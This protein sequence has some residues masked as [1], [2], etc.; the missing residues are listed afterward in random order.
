MTSPHAEFWALKTLV[1]A[2]V[3]RAVE[4]VLLRG[5]VGAKAVEWISE[6]TPGE[7]W[8]FEWCCAILDLDP[9]AVRQQLGDVRRP[10]RAA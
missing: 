9:G 8:S 6:R 5:R 1:A 10:V 3:Q 2:V 7:A 4:D